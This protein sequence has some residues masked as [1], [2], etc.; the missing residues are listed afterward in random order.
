MGRQSARRFSRNIRPAGR[1]INIANLYK[2]RHAAMACLFLYPIHKADG[3]TSDTSRRH[4]DSHRKRAPLPAL[5][6]HSCILHAIY[7]IPSESQQALDRNFCPCRQP[8]RHRS[9]QS[10]TMM[11]QNQ[12]DILVTKVKKHQLTKQNVYYEKTILP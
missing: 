6:T 2:K 8:K 4:A 10:K 11:R 9:A 12:N 5:P 7:F 3:E 1:R